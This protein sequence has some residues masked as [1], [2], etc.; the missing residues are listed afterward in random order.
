MQEIEY[1]ETNDIVFSATQA[2]NDDEYHFTCVCPNQIHASRT[3]VLSVLYV[4]F[5]VLIP[6]VT[7]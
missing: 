1:L 5:P 6:Q 3:K 7:Y 2:I 4:L